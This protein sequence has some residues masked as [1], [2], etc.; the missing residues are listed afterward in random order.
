MSISLEAVLVHL[1]RS[2]VYRQ[3]LSKE[4]CFYISLKHRRKVVFFSSFIDVWIYF[5]LQ[6]G[7][8]FF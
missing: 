7:H 1:L 4:C 6:S 3:F 5:Y 2:T 8:C